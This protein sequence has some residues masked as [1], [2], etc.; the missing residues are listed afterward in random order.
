[1]GGQR[2]REQLRQG[3]HIVDGLLGIERGHLVLDPSGGRERI[4]G[5]SHHDGHPGPALLRVRHVD[6][7]PGR[8]V[9]AGI[10]DVAHHAHHLECGRI[11]P[12]GPEAH[13]Q[14]LAERVLAGEDLGDQRFIDHRHRPR[15]TAVARVERAAALQWNAQRLEVA[16]GHG[17]VL[18]A[19]LLAR[20]RRG[21]AL[22]GEARG[23]AV[24]SEGLRRDGCRREHPG[25]GANA[26]EQLPVE[27]R[28]LVRPR[29]S[30]L[31]QRDA[32]GEDVVGVEAGIDREQPAEAL[33]HQAGPR[34]Q[35]ERQGDLG[36]DEG[37][38]AGVMGQAR[39]SAG[40][41][42]GLGDVGA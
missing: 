6:L 20:G 40:L 26:F 5:T 14:L 38:G 9:Q 3:P 17:A 36:D 34:H 7:W 21:P 32:D 25:P 2:A 41:V 16:R 15:V 22:H 30:R 4:A 24:A 37:A 27:R 35:H 10:V 29:V 33:Q 19:R 1:M 8:Q 28:A 23:D 18:G 12:V 39:A 11:A 13:A 42:Q 31:G